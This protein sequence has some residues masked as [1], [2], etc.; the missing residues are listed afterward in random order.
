MTETNPFQPA[1]L[2]A[3]ARPGLLSMEAGQT[4]TGVRAAVRE[5]GTKPGSGGRPYLYVRLGD[6]TGEV[7]ARCWEG[8]SLVETLAPGA[9]VEID[10]LFMDPRWGPVFQPRALRPVA[11][12]DYD[13]SEF[14]VTLPREV[15]EANWRELHEHLDSIENPDLQRLREAV[16]G[17]P[18]LAA[19]YKTHPSALKHHHNY[20]GGNVEHVLGIM[21]VVDAVCRSYRELDR[22]LVLFGAAVHD[23]GKLREYAVDTVIRVTEDGRLR[24]HLVI[25]AEW[26]GQMV[27]AARHDGHDVPAGIEQ[28]LVHMILSHHLKGEWGSPKPPA[29]PEAMLLHLADFADSQTKGFLQD[30]G[31]LRDFGDG[32][33]YRKDGDRSGWV[34]VRRDWE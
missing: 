24:G 28:H 20:L 8:A 31:E 33:S 22:D 15:I 25:G 5:A 21:H 26:L 34:R 12:G 19:A 6:P 11:P 1:N 13:P 7:E 9:V 4:Y 18:D 29:T 16:F 30:V 14:L 23:L 32:W 27:S 10:S 17:R 3:R 2:L